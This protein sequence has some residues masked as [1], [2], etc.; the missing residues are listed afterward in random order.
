MHRCE[1][2][3]KAGV[4][5]IHHSIIGTSLQDTVIAVAATTYDIMLIDVLFRDQKRRPSTNTLLGRSCCILSSISRS[6]RVLPLP[7]SWRTRSGTSSTGTLLLTLLG[8][9]SLGGGGRGGHAD[10]CTT[11]YFYATE[12][13]L[14]LLASILFNDYEVIVLLERYVA[15]GSVV[16]ISPLICL[17]SPSS[18]YYVL[19]FVVPDP[20]TMLDCL[21]CWGGSSKVLVG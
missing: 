6:R 15:I 2:G 16:P 9:H 4:P 20:T 1:Q 18:F 5:R 21:P 14:V 3:P 19:P 10:T 13:S 12:M 11:G 8:I 7:R 17:Y